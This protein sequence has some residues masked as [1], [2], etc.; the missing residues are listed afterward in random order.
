[1]QCKFM[2]I[3]DVCIFRVYCVSQ[4]TSSSLLHTPLF[5][6]GK[7]VPEAHCISLKTASVFAFE[8]VD[9]NANCLFQNKQKAPL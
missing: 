3:T 4:Y 8:Q 9:V 6:V 5:V 1:M 2:E 7:A